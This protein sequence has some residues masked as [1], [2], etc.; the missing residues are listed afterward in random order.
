MCCKP[1]QLP[2]PFCSALW[3]KLLLCI[4]QIL[5]LKKGKAL[6]K[7]KAL[8]RAMMKPVRKRAIGAGNSKPQVRQGFPDVDQELLEEKL[9]SY[10]RLLGKE[11]AFNMHQYKHL[12]PQK[13]EVAKDM[14]KLAKLL[15]ALLA[16]SPTGQIKYACL[17]Q[18]LGCLM[19]KF[20]PDL[21]SAH[22]D[23]E[24][25]LL[26]GR[27]ADCITILLK[28]WRRAASSTKSWE[29]FESKLDEAQAK[30]MGGLRKQMTLPC[31]EGKPNKK[32]TLKKEESEVTEGPDGYPMMLATQS[33]SEVGS[34]A[35]SSG[36]DGPESCLQGSPPP[37][38]KA[39]W[40]KAAGKDVKKVLETTYKLYIYY[41]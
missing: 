20:G 5:S 30:V 15:E 38:L 27:V 13:A 25:S 37:V 33:D 34:E 18:A 23:C 40:K 39:D 24:K 16:A 4:P 17:K 7:G 21:L 29:K 41:I 10:V 14:H 8:Q 36:G 12:Q 11:Q 22:F 6:E 3:L 1:L 31:E 28:H 32:R 26:V 19:K 35:A 9:D 2:C